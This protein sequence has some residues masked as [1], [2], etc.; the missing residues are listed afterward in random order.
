MAVS[1][2]ETDLLALDASLHIHLLDVL[3]EVGHAVSAGQDDLRNGAIGNEGSQTRQ[4]LLPAA[5]DAHEQ[6]VA[7]LNNAADSA[8]MLH[9]I[10]EKDEIHRG[11]GL[12]V[13]IE[14][15]SQNFV[16]L[17]IGLDSIVALFDR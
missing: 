14:R 13:R 4:R 2:E 8:D 5:A 9:G 6:C 12:V 11:I 16:Q 15:I 1:E 7:A 17:L 10:P 3:F